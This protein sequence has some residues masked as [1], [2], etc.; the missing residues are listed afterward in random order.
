MVYEEE[1][2]NNVYSFT[3]VTGS[4]IPRDQ[5]ATYYD[6]YRPLRESSRDIILRIENIDYI[7]SEEIEPTDWT[8]TGDWE[9][10]LGYRCLTAKGCYGGRQWSVA[11][12]CAA[13]G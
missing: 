2:R 7:Y 5:T 9:T 13:V 8:I 3:N 6:I 4:V 10:I 1:N 12:R 11:S